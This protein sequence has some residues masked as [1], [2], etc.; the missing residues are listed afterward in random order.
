MSRF[1]KRYNP[2]YLPTLYYLGGQ[3][4]T[5]AGAGVALTI[6]PEAEI[7]DIE[8]SG[9]GS[10]YYEI[11]DNDHGALSHGHIGSS[12]YRQLGPFANM[13]SLSVYGAAG[14]YAHVK[15]YRRA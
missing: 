15:Y 12:A 6:P 11:N 7:V 5:L 4:V 1:L 9:Q 2:V 3:T 13:T 8:V 10:L 14:V